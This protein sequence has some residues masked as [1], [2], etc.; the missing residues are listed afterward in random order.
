MS[1]LPPQDPT[2]TLP[3][4][5]FVDDEEKTRK[6]F[7][8]LFRRQFNILLAE[9]GIEGF[10]V[11]QESINE[12]GVIVTDQRM[13]NETGTE[14]LQKAALLKPGVI[15]I[16]STAYAEV[17]AA[18]DSV[19]KGGVYRYITKPWEVPDLEVTLT[20][21]VELYQL[22]SERNELV[23]QKLTS[24]QDLAATE[25][26]H[27]L[28]ALAVFQNS[29]LRHSSRALQA[30]VQLADQPGNPGALPAQGNPNWSEV[31]HHHRHFLEVAHALLPTTLAN[32]AP[33]DES[34][35]VSAAS[36][37]QTVCE[38]DS[39]FQWTETEHKSIAWPGPA[40]LVAPITQRLFEGLGAILSQADL[41]R[42][43]ETEHGI[44]LSVSTLALQHG[45][46]PLLSPSFSDGPDK[47]RSLQVTASFLEWAHHGG[48]MQILPDPS[49]RTV[50]LRLGFASPG[51]IHDPWE[52]L[53]A[54]LVANDLFWQ[55][56][57]D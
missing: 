13:P 3:T 30:L 44:E 32:S 14:F 57:L 54:D 48:S 25:R 43:G 23:R 7:K 5:L 50:S 35:L 27:S 28:A 11:F 9:D 51:P 17:D 12:I 2:N 18:I 34:N 4:I 22:Q 42:A 49:S 40:D 21:A 38:T 45:L 33:L 29:G 31:Y 20:R 52:T 39:R 41:I 46:Q 19:N 6:H 1:T 26:I 56:H 37:V 36:I 24:L 8:R 55:R 15:R 53:A 47:N 16:L 10:R